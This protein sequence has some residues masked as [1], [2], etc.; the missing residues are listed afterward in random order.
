MATPKLISHIITNTERS[1]AKY[2]AVQE[3]FPNSV[4]NTYYEFIDKTV[5]QKYTN[6]YFEKSYNGLYVLPYCEVNFT[7]EDKEESVKI[8][9]SP[10]R[11]KLVHLTWNR[12][13]FSKKRIMKFSRMAINLK[14]NNFKNEMINS[15]KTQIM[16]FVKANPDYHLDTNHLDERLKK[17]LL[18]I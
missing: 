10:K 15:C 12:D 1:L 18:F 4:M 11:N 2:K 9:S 16:T 7:F 14:T 17:L 3:E 6:F 13:P 8:H 5:N